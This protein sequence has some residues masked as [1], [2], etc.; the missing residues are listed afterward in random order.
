[1]TSQ[2][3]SA[4]SKIMGCAGAYNPLA[5]YET[6]NV[7][8]ELGFADYLSQQFTGEPLIIIKHAKSRLSQ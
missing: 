7:G 3:A 6:K 4:H 2:L 5:S 8:A 1:M